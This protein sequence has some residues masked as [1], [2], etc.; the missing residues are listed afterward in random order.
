MLLTSQL[1]AV[2]T[3]CKTKCCVICWKPLDNV[4]S[5]NTE[6]PV[7][8]IAQCPLVLHGNTLLKLVL[9]SADASAGTTS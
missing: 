4:Y 5:I 7:I 1:Q 2:H 8:S 3:A 9:P 6:Q